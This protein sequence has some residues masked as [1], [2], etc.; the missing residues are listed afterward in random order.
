MIQ[1]IQTVYFF[2]AAASFAVLFILPMAISDQAAGEFLADKV[3]SV[4][5]HPA[6]LGLTILGSVLAV[7]SIFFYKNRSLQ[8]KL[9]YLVILLAI[10]LPLVSFLLFKGATS[11]LGSTVTVQHQAGWFVPAGAFL[12][13]LLAIRYIRKD[14]RLVKSMDRLR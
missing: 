8:V 5:D 3:Y 7:V 11:T 14:E 13:G 6:L 9:A 2:L 1:R 10:I 12:F 4:T